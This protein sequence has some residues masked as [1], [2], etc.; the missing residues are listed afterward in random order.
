[1]PQAPSRRAQRSAQG[2]QRA[3]A[4]VI[5]LTLHRKGEVEEWSGYATRKLLGLAQLGNPV[6]PDGMARAVS[7]LR[8]DGTIIT[9]TDETRT[10]SIKLAGRLS[11]ETLKALQRDEPWAYAFLRGEL[12]LPSPGGGSLPEITFAEA[13]DEGRLDL[14]SLDQASEPTDSESNNGFSVSPDVAVLMRIIAEQAKTIRDLRA[15][16]GHPEEGG[17]SSEVVE[18]LTDVISQ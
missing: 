9:K 6:V 3:Y 4:T 14:D 16:L 11:G 1:M 15:E 7:K 5:L 13:D 2:T 17:L 18:F 12:S 8:G 10:C